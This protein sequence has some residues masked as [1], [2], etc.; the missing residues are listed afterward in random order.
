MENKMTFE[1]AMKRLEEINGQLQKNECPL[2]DAIE[3][4]KEGL[5][6]AQL[7][8]DKLNSLSKQLEDISEDNENDK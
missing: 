6:L 5:E 8:S 2:D 4:Y 3:L 7:C 1:Q